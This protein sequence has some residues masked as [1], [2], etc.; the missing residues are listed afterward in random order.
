VHDDDFNNL[1][2]SSGIVGIT[3]QDVWRSAEGRMQG[4]GVK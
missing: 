3:K 2:F 4:Q 1:H